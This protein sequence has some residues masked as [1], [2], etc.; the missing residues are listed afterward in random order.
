MDTEHEDENEKEIFDRFQ[1][2]G[3]KEPN[4]KEKESTKDLSFSDYLSHIGSL[5]QSF[6]E[7]I[8]N[9]FNESNF[10]GFEHES[11]NIINSIDTVKY[12]R[13]PCH[14]DNT[15][16]T[17]QIL[18]SLFNHILETESEEL[19]GYLFYCLS[20]LNALS[21]LIPNILDENQLQP[22]FSFITHIFTNIQNKEIHEM[23]IKTIGH[24]TE[25][26]RNSAKTLKSLLFMLIDDCDKEDLV[27]NYQILEAMKPFIFQLSKIGIP[28]LQTVLLCIC[29]HLQIGEKEDGSSAISTIYATEMLS[30]II[31][32]NYPGTSEL[33]M[34]HQPFPFIVSMLSRKDKNVVKPALSA[35][36]HA[37]RTL[38][39][40]NIIATDLDINELMELMG[41]SDV[42]T[43]TTLLFSVLFEKKLETVC[44]IDPVAL[45]NR[46]LELIPGA[47]QDIKQALIHLVRSISE[48]TETEIISNFP[49]EKIAEM[50]V[51]IV[52]LGN[53]EV[54]AEILT[55]FASIYI[56][57]RSISIPQEMIQVFIEHNGVECLEECSNSDFDELVEIAQQLLELIHQDSPQ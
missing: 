27:S 44:D 52:E 57:M 15:K 20:V 51:S 49:L 13:A 29:S 41:N 56:K 16:Q 39:C 37:I 19:Y 28:Q 25:S 38:R 17:V 18:F 32:S 7:N 48:N 42:S 14:N 31:S 47:K 46:T 12:P 3:D 26:T 34:R 36:Q 2:N 33:L 55:A 21:Q 6:N 4:R 54:S 11:Q 35:I 5:I 50:T 40:A 53:D 23:A 1:I 9:L 10:E 22:F 45:M 43:E 24:V 8:E 30:D